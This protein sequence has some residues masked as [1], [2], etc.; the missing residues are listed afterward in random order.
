[1]TTRVA[2]IVV[3]GS[4]LAVW[5]CG[6][7]TPVSPDQSAVQYSQVDLVV[8][9]GATATSGSIVTVTYSGWL[10]SDTA[11][12]HKGTAFGSGTFNFTIGANQV[13]PGFEQG[14]TGMQ[15]GGTRRLIVP[16]SLADGSQGSSQAGIPPNAALVF[17][18]TLN[19]VQ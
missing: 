1:M 11:T 19:S 9:S 13:I 6:S 10:Y 2:V 12:D 8:G 3:L 17:E 16:P 4:A 14:V 15:V 18:V 7:S 5:G